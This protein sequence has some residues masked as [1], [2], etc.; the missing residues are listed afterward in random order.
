MEEIMKKLLASILAVL[1][2]NLVCVASVGADSRS[3]KDAKTAAK[4]KSAIQQLGTG[5]GAYV[6][7]RLRDG[8]RLKGYVDE[9]GDDTFIVVEEKTGGSRQVPY[10]QVRQVKGNNL[11]TGA[12][13]AIGVG[14]G[15]VIL[16]LVFKD[17][18]NAY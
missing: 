6:D 16:V 8:T 5:P 1:M 11:S 13:V 10:P 15:L 3:D 18:I 2:L 14:V 12:K 9:A 17:H 7:L 4:I